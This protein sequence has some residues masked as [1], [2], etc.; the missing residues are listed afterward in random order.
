MSDSNVFYLYESLGNV[1]PSIFNSLVNIQIIPCIKD[2]ETEQIYVLLGMTQQGFVIELGDKISKSNTIPN[3]ISHKLKSNTLGLINLS[4]EYIQANTYVA[5]ATS[6]DIETGERV[7]RKIEL[8]IFFVNIE[9]NNIDDLNDLLINFREKYKSYIKKVILSDRINVTNL[10]YMDSTDL[11]HFMK[12]GVCKVQDGENV[13]EINFEEEGFPALEAISEIYKSDEEAG[14]IPI[15]IYYNENANCSP[16]VFFYKNKDS[17]L[18]KSLLK[19][20]N[21]EL[22]IIM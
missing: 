7:L 15:T 14:D 3:F 22:P 10:I 21:V 18:Q 20:F 9:I 2:K 19:Y 6:L 11:Y 4:T 13:V 5:Y 1:K 12:G 17:A 8:P 16:E